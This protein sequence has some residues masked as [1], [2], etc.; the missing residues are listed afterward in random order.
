MNQLLPPRFLDPATPPSMFTLV[1]YASL[2][3]VAMNIFLPSMPAIADHFNA[4]Y[5][6]VQF[7]LSGFLLMNGVLQLFIGPISDRYGRRP[8]ALYTLAAFVAA[9]IVCAMAPSTAVLLTARTFQALVVSSFVLSRAAAR[10]MVPGDNAASML[11]YIA[12]G[13]SV[14]PMMGPTIGGFLQEAFGWR[15][16]FWT[17][18]AV[19]TCVLLLVWRDMGE[20]NLNPSA[21]MAA[22]MRAYPQ[23]FKSRRFWGYALANTFATGCFFS[24]LG[25]APFV[26]VEIYGLTPAELGLYFIFGPM[27]Y[28]CGS[29]VS[30]RFAAKIGLYRMITAGACVTIFGM[31]LALLLAQL[32]FN[33]PVAFFGCTIFLG[34]GNGL[35]L[36]SASAG[37]MS[38]NPRLA[39]TA[40]GLSGALMTLGGGAMSAL[41]VPLLSVE[42]GVTPLILFILTSAVFGLFAALY[43]IRVEYQVRNTA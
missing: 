17:L 9:S 8:V 36:P 27:G 4:S 37:A 28:F 2:G 14:A 5:F 40:A 6:A 3:A 12:M 10:D 23:L 35:V 34:F 22:Q 13:M 16:P 19:G 1:I 39:G 41:V 32:G 24:L 33:H 30:G 18:A 38:V 29:L 15:A 42:A 20:T 25:G 11:G 26:G 21:S 7:M 43:S 31:L